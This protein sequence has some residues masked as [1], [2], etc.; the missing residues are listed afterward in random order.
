MASLLVDAEKDVP[1]N[2]VI[3]RISSDAAAKRIFELQEERKEEYDKLKR[4]DIYNYI[5][6]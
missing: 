6:I 5:N 3:S 1:A 4:F 2:L